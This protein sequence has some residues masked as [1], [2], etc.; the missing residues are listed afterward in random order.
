MRCVR[1]R[2]KW[3][4]PA[5]SSN[6]WMVQTLSTFLS[7]YGSAL[8]LQRNAAS[9]SDPHDQQRRFDISCG[10]MYRLHSAHG[11]EAFY[12]RFLPFKG[13]KKRISRRMPTACVA[14]RRFTA[15]FAMH[16]CRPV[17]SSMSS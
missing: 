5:T 11:R 8:P 3:K 17:G 10:T 16:G 2:D 13:G 14:C 6:C 12:Q 7:A 1:I 15:P 9:W 4:L